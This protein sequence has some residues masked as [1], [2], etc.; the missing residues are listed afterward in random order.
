MAT[1]PVL[2]AA[3]RAPTF[4]ITL[5]PSFAEAVAHLS[6]FTPTPLVRLCSSRS[7]SQCC[8][9]AHQDLRGA[10]PVSLCRRQA[11]A[12]TVRQ[13]NN[14]HTHTS[15]T[16]PAFLC[17]AHPAVDQELRPSSGPND[18]TSSSAVALQWPRPHPRLQRLPDWSPTG[19]PLRSCSAVMGS[20]I[21]VSHS[22]PPPPNQLLPPL[23]FSSTPP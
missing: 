7:S 21:P 6:T 9:T 11:S 10:R 17:C 20:P 23:G 2:L 19:I 1:A 5:I 13:V 16:S 15:S 3:P 18:A 4:A 8:T 12:P 22:I 14:R